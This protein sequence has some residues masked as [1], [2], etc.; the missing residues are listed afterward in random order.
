MG[1]KK[2]GSGSK[3]TNGNVTNYD[4]LSDKEENV[5]KCGYGKCTPNWLQAFNSS[6]ALLAAVSWFAFV[7]SKLSPCSTI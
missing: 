7:Q 1:N 2:N 6:K 5:M 4:S 3:E